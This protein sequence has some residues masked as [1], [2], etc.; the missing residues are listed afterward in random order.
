MFFHGGGDFSC[1]FEMLVE[2]VLDS[3]LNVE[4]E[5]SEGEDSEAINLSLVN[6]LLD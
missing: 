3:H 6:M 1:T 4:D 5:G 2:E